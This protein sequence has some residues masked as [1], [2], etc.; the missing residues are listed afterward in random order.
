MSPAFDAVGVTD[1]CRLN[2]GAWVAFTVK[3]DAG[4]D[5]GAGLGLALVGGGVPVAIAE[6]LV[7]P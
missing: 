7:E 4:D 3:G 5:T 1:F 2:D 6:S